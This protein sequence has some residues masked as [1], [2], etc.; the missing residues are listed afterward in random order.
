MLLGLLSRN[1]DLSRQERRLRSLYFVS[2]FYACKE[3]MN[4]TLKLSIEI[5]HSEREDV[6]R[7]GPF[8]KPLA[9]GVDLGDEPDL[10]VVSLPIDNL[11]LDIGTSIVARLEV[12][13][14]LQTFHLN[15]GES[16]DS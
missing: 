10:V 9:D 5:S 3:H 16:S 15:I 14:E 2:L 13:D 1:V 12:E 11:P 7:R 4:I 6:V 8:I